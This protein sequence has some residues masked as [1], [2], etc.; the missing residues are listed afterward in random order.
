LD[1]F[2]C[3][4]PLFEKPLKDFVGPALQ[5]FVRIPVKIA[6]L[7]DEVDQNVF[8]KVHWTISFG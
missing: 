3:N 8:V 2:G 5:I 1:I 6:T 4:D 7:A